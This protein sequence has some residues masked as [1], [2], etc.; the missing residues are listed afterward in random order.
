MTLMMM[1]EDEED[2]RIRLN[3]RERL[4]HQHVLSQ[5]SHTINTIYG[6]VIT[7]LVGR[8]VVRASTLVTDKI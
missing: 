1:I 7:V 8:N 6:T 4:N 2:L 5:L 3:Q